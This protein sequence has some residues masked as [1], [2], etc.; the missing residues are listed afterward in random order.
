MLFYTFSQSELMTNY[1]TYLLFSIFIEPF[2]LIINLAS[3]EFTITKTFS[4][5]IL[6]K[7]ITDFTQHIVITPI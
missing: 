1:M 7:S 4:I 2:T 5:N 3:T 6:H